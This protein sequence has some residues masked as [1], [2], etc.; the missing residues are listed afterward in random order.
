MLRA[1]T[2]VVGPESHYRPARR[3][4]RTQPRDQ[5]Q[6]KRSKN[7]PGGDLT[8]EGRKLFSTPEGETVLS[9]AKSILG[10]SDEMLYQL[11]SR[12]S[13][14]MSCS[15]RRTSC[16]LCCFRSS[17]S[18]ERLSSGAVELTARLSTRWSDV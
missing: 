11:A 7:S 16:A 2:S 14:D 12:L 6:L 13:R 1:L 9:Y 17:R 3:L 8:H 10:F 5:S 15:A 18:C 4:G